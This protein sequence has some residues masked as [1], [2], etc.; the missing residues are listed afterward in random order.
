LDD[1][2]AVAASSKHS[3]AIGQGKLWQWRTG[4]APEAV[5]ACT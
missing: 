2:L 1:V 4:D 5:M 3:I